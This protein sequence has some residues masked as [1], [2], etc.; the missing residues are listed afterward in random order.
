[1]QLPLEVSHA[2]TQCL[3]AIRCLAIVTTVYLS[4]CILSFLPTFEV[5]VHAVGGILAYLT[6]PITIAGCMAYINSETR[7]LRTEVHANQQQQQQQKK[8][9]AFPVMVAAPPPTT[10][11][12]PALRAAHLEKLT[13]LFAHADWK[14]LPRPT[15]TTPNPPKLYDLSTGEAITPMKLIGTINCHASKMVDFIWSSDHSVKSKL[16]ADL[17]TLKILHEFSPDM[18]IEYQRVSTPRFVANRDMCYI[19][20]RHNLPENVTA[21]TLIS[22]DFPGAPEGKDGCVRAKMEAFWRVTP[23]AENMCQV[24]WGVKADP[25]G[26]IPKAIINSYKTT[27]PVTYLQAIRTFLE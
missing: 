1:M 10:Q 23:M 22:T 12:D 7:R 9:P 8:K 15:T 17:M 20:T 2:L 5:P 11:E 6:L 25:G 27:Q 3:Q 4:L 24:E 21:Y 18:K 19:K 14:E 16:S 26:Y 13:S